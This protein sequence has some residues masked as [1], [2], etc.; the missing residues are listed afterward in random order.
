MLRSASSSAPLRILG[1]VSALACAAVFAYL[2]GIV[3]IVASNAGDAR[4]WIWAGAWGLAPL[5]MTIAFSVH[6]IR[7]PGTDGY[8]LIGAAC[9]GGIFM[10]CIALFPFVIF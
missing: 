5:A 7:Q 4:L 9:L 1:Y 10:C 6:V 8:A 2:L 3:F